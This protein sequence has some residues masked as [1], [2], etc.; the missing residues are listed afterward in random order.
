MLEL[1]YEMKATPSADC[2]FTEQR[3]KQINK[4]T[5]LSTID[6]TSWLD[7]SH[8]LCNTLEDGASK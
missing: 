5:I 1:A 2:R 8:Y 3:I 4:L 6:E 7:L